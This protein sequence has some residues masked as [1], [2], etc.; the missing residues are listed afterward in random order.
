MNDIKVSI[1][2]PVFNSEKYLSV[3]IESCIKQTLKDIEI[4][5][6]NDGSTDNSLNIC[7]EFSQKD[8]RIKVISKENEGVSVARNV[9]IETARGEYIQFVDADDFLDNKCIEKAY[10]QISKEDSDMLFFGFKL[11][12]QNKEESVPLTA[13]YSLKENPF[14]LQTLEALTYTI[15]DKL[16]KKSFL[17]QNGIRFVK[18]LIT[19]EDGVFNL[20]CL[21]NIPKTSFLT[22]HLYNYRYLSEGSATSRLKLESEIKTFKTF[23]NMPQFKKADFN[24]KI[25]ALNKSISTLLRWYYDPICAE[26][27]SDNK[28]KCIKLH[29]QLLKTF[30]LAILLKCRSYIYFRKAFP[31][32]Q[33][34]LKFIEKFIILFSTATQCV[35]QFRLFN[36]PIF[37][38][39]VNYNKPKSQRISLPF[40]SKNKS[41]SDNVDK[42]QTFY[43]KINRNDAYAL[44]CLQH[45]VDI[46]SEIKG[47]FYI[48]CDKPEL[49]N[50]ILNTIRFKNKNIK[51]IKSIRNKK[52]REIAKNISTPLWYNATYAHLTP[53][54]HAKK[55]NIKDF[56]NIDADDTM[57]A[58]YADRVASILTEV[59]N[60]AQLN[61]ID[62][63]S[64]DMH[65]SKTSYKHWSFGIC[66]INNNSNWQNI[67]ES[68]ND[69]IWRKNYKIYDNQSNLDWF[70]TYL[71][72]ENIKNIKSFYIKNI[73][74]I[75]FGDFLWNT[76]D[77]GVFHYTDKEIIAPILNQAFGAKEYG[78]I[79]INNACIAFD[80][81]NSIKDGQTFMR[82]YQTYLDEPSL[83]K[84]NLWLK[85][86]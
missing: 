10:N 58:L 75:H 84:E 69:W 22:E 19:A 25:M 77:S 36:I 41:Y 50:K 7:N 4:I 11:I 59:K 70:F 56:W 47:D 80:N 2:I 18:G 24:L 28:L 66:Y 57:F 3:C 6:I 38:Y 83:M 79:L 27:M 60:Y 78:Q 34:L 32:N 42:P 29:K 65:T 51:F 48:I 9:G 26:A 68:N 54:Y 37:E 71:R 46:I 81:N 76:M 31:I 35:L 12:K 5:L 14:D 15:W 49:E 16:Y 44:R 61:D 52:F 73:Q 21:F 63:F 86:E 13:L 74:F 20:L 17:I 43:L 55:Y 67:F 64:F 1:I 72:D 62:A 40:L 8:P 33:F 23:I 45:W 53:F 82:K 85:N 30:G 39:S